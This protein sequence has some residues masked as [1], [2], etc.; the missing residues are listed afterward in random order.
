M[1]RQQRQYVPGPN[2]LTMSAVCRSTSRVVMK[3]LIAIGI[4][5]A[6]RPSQAALMR[7]F[8]TEEVTR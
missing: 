8:D 7:V 4:T 5:S 1:A 3:P 6:D 2:S